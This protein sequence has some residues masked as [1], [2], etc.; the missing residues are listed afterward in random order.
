MNTLPAW[1]TLSAKKTCSP[2][3]NFFLRDGAVGKKLIF[4]PQWKTMSA[5]NID[6]LTI[7]IDILA[8]DPNLVEA[9]G[10]INSLARSCHAMAATIRERP[11]AD[12]FARICRPPGRGIRVEKH[13]LPNG[14][15]HGITR[16]YENDQY[17]GATS[18]R[19]LYDRGQPTDWIFHHIDADER[20]VYKKYG[21]IGSN[22]WVI[23]DDDP[24]DANSITPEYAIYAYYKIAESPEPHITHKKIS[25]AGLHGF[26]A[27]VRMNMLL[28]HEW[29]RL[30]YPDEV[31]FLANT[32][33]PCHWGEH[34]RDHA[35]GMEAYVEDE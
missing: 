8:I 29:V 25:T 3:V 14:T 23:V 4:P 5:L 17:S 35:P 34:I 16:F 13:I 27:D 9:I 12:K 30:Q 1:K 2:A 10:A 6:V 28:I 20:D 11:I 19:I 33:I 21:R 24:W 26:C 31:P 7:I 15:N 18:I 22:V 32:M